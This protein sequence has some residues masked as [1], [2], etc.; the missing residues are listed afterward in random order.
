LGRI[1]KKKA[2]EFEDNGNNILN[3]FREKMQENMTA[4]CINDIKRE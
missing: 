3:Y 1:G 2:E 4:E